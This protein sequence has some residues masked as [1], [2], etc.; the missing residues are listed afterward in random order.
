MWVAGEMQRLRTSSAGHVYFELVEKGPRD[1]IIGKLDCAIFRRDLTRVR[2]VLRRSGQELVEGREIRCRGDLDFYP[3]GGR[4]QFIVR[5][6]DAVF[7]L[8][9]MEQRRREVLE[10]L[11]KSGLH[12]RNRALEMPAVP[13]RIGLV[14]SEG[15][16]A[17]HD[18]V[19]SLEE[20]GYA[21]E[22]R[23]VHAPVQGSDAA[24]RVAR[25]LEALRAIR[26]DCVVLTRGGGARSDLAAFDTREVAEAIA[27]SPFP[28]LTGLGHEIDESIADS[29]AHA[30]FKTPTKV[31]EFLVLRVA[32]VEARLDQIALALV[33]QGGLRL[34]RSLHRLESMAARLPM[35]VGRVRLAGRRVE[36]LRAR[37]AG[38]AR[39]AIDSARRHRR[40]ISDRLCRAAPRR[41][42][43]ST[44]AVQALVRRVV[45]LARARVREER[46]RIESMARLTE[47]LAPTRVLA[48]GFSLTR[49][50]D[51]KLVRS[52]TEVAV[53]ERISTELAKGRVESR[54]ESAVG[55]G[56]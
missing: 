26:V 48:R 28:V 5:D 9:L 8:G 4:L 52:S 33:R 37:T 14:T 10:H 34:E 53:G 16:A 35:V 25:A 30:A 54:V 6:I 55:G 40:E 50:P 56:K 3:A 24:G 39:I 20:S 2:S 45:D 11:R 27:T 36:E 41:L 15:S 42:V 18:F 46:M 7:S 17:Y 21:F 43:E 44:P 12:D 32:T 1:A 19:S 31:A 47:E 22:L 23:F 49:G 38:A 51:G 13:L 29:V